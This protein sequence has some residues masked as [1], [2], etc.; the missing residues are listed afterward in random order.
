M[1]QRNQRKRRNLKSKDKRRK[2]PSKQQVIP[3]AKDPRSLTN[4]RIKWTRI[5]QKLNL[6]IG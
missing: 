2:N 5:K 3:E 6:N 1:H 4:D